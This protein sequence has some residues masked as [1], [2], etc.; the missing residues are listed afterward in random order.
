MTKGLSP[1]Q[2]YVLSVIFYILRTKKPAGMIFR[3][4]VRVPDH[5]VDEK[6]DQRK[7]SEKNHL[8]AGS[9]YTLNLK[10]IT[11]PSRTT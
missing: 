2:R 1:Y 8:P 3:I 5:R 11:S 4:P 9:F 7:K 10:S 6:E